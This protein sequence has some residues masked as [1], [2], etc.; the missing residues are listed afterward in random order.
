VMKLMVV[1]VY[2]LKAV[3][4]QA[5]VEVARAKREALS[6]DMLPRQQMQTRRAFPSPAVCRDADRSS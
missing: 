5:V 1:R 2:C 3:D 4:I 6:F